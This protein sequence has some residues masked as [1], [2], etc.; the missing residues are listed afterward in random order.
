MKTLIEFNYQTIV[1]RGM[2]NKATSEDD[3][4]M[5]LEEEVQEFINA[6]KNNIGDFNEELAD[7]ILV[8][9]NIAKHYGIDI[10][11]ELINKILKNTK[12]K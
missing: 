2:I 5:K 9:L 4:I 7:I 3:F 10:E 12:R 8:C 6:S 1:N 11:K